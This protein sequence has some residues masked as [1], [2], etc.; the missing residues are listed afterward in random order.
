MRLPQRFGRIDVEQ[1]KKMVDRFLGAGFTYFD[2]AFVY[3]GSAADC[4]ECRRCE[5]AGT[6]DAFYYAM[7]PSFV[8]KGYTL[9]YLREL[10]KAVKL[11]ILAGARMA[12]PDLSESAIAEGVID[13]AVIGRAAIADPDYAKKIVESRSEDIRTCIGCNQGCIWGYFTSGQVGCAVNPTVGHEKDGEIGK[14]DRRKKVLVV[15]G[16]IAGMEAARIAA[17]RGHDVTLCEK[18]DRL[19]GNL[20]PAGSHDFKSEVAELNAYFIHQTESLPI[21]V[22]LGTEV[23]PDMVREMKPDAVI[24]A[25]GSTSVMPRSI[26]GIDHPKTVSGVDACLGKKPVGQRVVIVGGGLV[27]CEIAFG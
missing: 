2:T 4:I 26:E 23:T 27:G 1:V 18:S 7:P 19:G 25:V 17:L 12:D 9:P 5:D 14:V 20:I 22:R 15:G 3:T 13:A 8:E 24:L 16:G 6:L 10:R 21:D 11:P